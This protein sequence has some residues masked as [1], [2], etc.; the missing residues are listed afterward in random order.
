MGSGDAGS[1]AASPARE[2]S[3]GAYLIGS[4]AE[5]NRTAAAVD[6]ASQE[7]ERGL[8]GDQDHLVRVNLG[9]REQLRVPRSVADYRTLSGRL[10]EGVPD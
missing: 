4:R 8:R 5:A 7:L 9:C 2:R 10:R 3:A 6:C 1:L